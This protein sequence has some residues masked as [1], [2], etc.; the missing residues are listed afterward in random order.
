MFSK[1]C[2]EFLGLHSF[3][4]VEDRWQYAADAIVWIRL[5]IGF[6]IEPTKS[7]IA[8]PAVQTCKLIRV[9]RVRPR[10]SSKYYL[11]EIVSPRLPVLGLGI[12]LFPQPEMVCIKQCEIGFDL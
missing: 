5:E 11:V 12:R 2:Y 10:H 3:F 9:E 7:H 4:T 6:R 8:E 1:T